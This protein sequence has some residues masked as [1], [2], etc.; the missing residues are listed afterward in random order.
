[1]R[2]KILLSLNVICIALWT[3]LAIS[4]PAS[5]DFLQGLSAFRNGDYEAAIRE[6]RSSA[7]VG[8]NQVL[9]WLGQSYLELARATLK[10]G[11]DYRSV[12]DTGIR[13]L[14][15]FAEEG[16]SE[17]EYSLGLLYEFRQ[18]SQEAIRWFRRAAE[19]EHAMAQ[20]TLGSMYRVG[21]IGGQG[22]DQDF[23]EAR[24]WFERAANNGEHLGMESLGRLYAEGKGV[25]KNYLVA[26]KWLERAI[27]KGNRG[28]LVALGSMYEHGKGVPKNEERARELYRKAANL[29]DYVAKRILEEKPL[30]EK[31]NAEAQFWI[32]E[33]WLGGDGVVEDIDEALRCL[34]KAAEQGYVSAI[35]T[36]GFIYQK[37]WH[38]PQDFVLAHKWYNIA[39]SLEDQKSRWDRDEVARLMTPEQ[40]GEAQNLAREWMTSHR[41]K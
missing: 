1:M 4:S 6:F 8:D 23:Y 27:E 22:V 9:K 20:W 17:S 39:A 32:G 37:G 10:H 19:R 2:K 18:N 29:G 34:E 21:K 14:H 13:D 40:I 26:I 24:R 3:G 41:K 28:A 11:G 5:T 33:R 38:A 35:R 31:G 25:A 36:L 30:A 12:I 15:P 7:H 16:K